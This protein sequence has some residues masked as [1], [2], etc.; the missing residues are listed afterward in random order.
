M[1]CKLDKSTMTC[2]LGMNSGDGPQ[3]CLINVMASPLLS[4]KH[5][6]NSLYIIG[7]SS[8][9]ILRQG[10]TFRQA[11]AVDLVLE[12]VFSVNGWDG[13]LLT[14]C[15]ENWKRRRL[16]AHVK[17]FGQLKHEAEDG[18][19]AVKNRTSILPLVVEGDALGV[20][21]PI[22]EKKLF[23]ASLYLP[24]LTVLQNERIFDKS[25]VHFN[26]TSSNAK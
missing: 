6:Y 24:C 22:I 17:F 1:R 9:D 16:V 2:I 12:I 21:L 23:F 15:Q 19:L 20:G 14:I 26:T 4:I 7:C 3:A 5:V 18:V 11:V 25:K 10:C 13:T 8:F